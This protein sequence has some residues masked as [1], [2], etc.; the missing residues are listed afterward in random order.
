MATAIENITELAQ[1][2]YYTVNGVENDDTDE[3][4]TIFQNSFIRAFNLWTQEY[5]T[6]AYWNRLRV[7]DHVLGVITGITTYS[8]TLSDEYRTPVFNENQYLKF[9]SDGVTIASFKMVNP[10]QRQVDDEVSRPDR[11]TFVD[12]NK[13]VL[14]RV[15]TAEEV[16]AEMV[17]DV[18][19]AFPKLTR[20]D[21][22]AITY[23]HK[24]Q[25]AVLGIAKNEA[26]SDVTKVSLSPSFAQKYKNELDK[27]IAANDMSSEINDMR[28]ND[29]S[30]IGGVW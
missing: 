7:N 18:V 8:F 9:V 19:L 1:D 4:E 27:A 28:G 11:A 12:D 5:E 6:E 24:T 10:N 26:L 20:T 3:D 22:T 15:P 23:L 17:L 21:D 2:V 16:G 25:L 29:Y 13:I 30:S 14:S